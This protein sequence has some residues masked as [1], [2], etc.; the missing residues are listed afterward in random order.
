VDVCS[1]CG[2]AIKGGDAGCQKLA[3]ELWA[4]DFSNA[5]YFRSHRLMVDTY[6]LQHPDRYCDSAKSFAAHLGGLCCAFEHR[7]DPAALDTLQR[8]LSKNPVLIRPPL[9]EKRGARTIAEVRVI[10]DPAAYAS[11]VERWARSTWEAYEPLHE[12]ARGWIEESV[13]ARDAR[14]R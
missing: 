13:A 11:A 14:K 4:R 10:Q 3:D 1:G 12:M 9:P 2:I 6:A 7:T 8:W 5:L